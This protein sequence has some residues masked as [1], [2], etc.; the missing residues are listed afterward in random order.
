MIDKDLASA[1]LAVGLGADVL[2]LATD[3]DAVYTGWGTPRERAVSRTTPSWL[4]A[5]RFAGGSMGP[6]VEAACR[7]VEATGKRAA[8]GRLE[9][10]SGLIEGATGTQIRADGP[11]PGLGAAS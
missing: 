8:I 7:F 4:R 2:A 9:D 6:K 5:Q 10:L 11:P 3:V 1:L